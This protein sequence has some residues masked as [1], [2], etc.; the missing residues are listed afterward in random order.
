MNRAAAPGHQRFP[1]K[2]ETK[3][4]RLGGDDGAEEPVERHREPAG[5]KEGKEREGKEK[6]R[7]R[8]AVEK[9]TRRSDRESETDWFEKGFVPVFSLALVPLSITMDAASP[10]R[11][12]PLLAGVAA[13][14]ALFDPKKKETRCEVCFFTILKLNR[15]EKL[16]LSLKEPKPASS[17][18]RLR[19]SARPARPSSPSG[20]PS[21]H[22]WR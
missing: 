14:R 3:I 10:C 8:K 9:K 7:K 22:R 2:Q 16:T 6:E 13:W 5:R 21:R 11:A 17:P 4:A 20:R 1:V 18:L 15:G 12:L 19:A